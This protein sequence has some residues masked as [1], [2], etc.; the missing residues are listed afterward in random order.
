MATKR[1]AA[2]QAPITE[3]AFQQDILDSA[4][5]LGWLCFHTFDSRRS[6][7][8]FPDIIAIRGATMLCLEVKDEDGEPSSAQEE[9]LARFQQ[10]KYVEASLVRPEHRDQVNDVLNRALR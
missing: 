9:W 3:K 5:K 1:K 6:E 2:Q 7:P 10:V 4:R 8:G